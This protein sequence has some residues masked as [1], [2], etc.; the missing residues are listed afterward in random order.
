MVDERLGMGPMQESH[1]NKTFKTQRPFLQYE[2][3]KQGHF[4]LQF[5]TCGA[6]ASWGKNQKTKTL[7]VSLLSIS[8]TKNHMFCLEWCSAVLEEN[9]NNNNGALSSSQVDVS[10]WSIS[11]LSSGNVHHFFFLILQ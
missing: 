11:A 3:Q 10:L 6:Y 2:A 9:N 4:Q 7:Q 1:K 5:Y 8:L